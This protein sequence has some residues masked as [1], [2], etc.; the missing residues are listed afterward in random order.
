MEMVGSSN[1][2]YAGWMIG[3]WRVISNRNRRNDVINGRHA[4]VPGEIK[5]TTELTYSV[6]RPFFILTDFSQTVS[7]WPIIRAYANGNIVPINPYA[8]TTHFQTYA[9]DFDEIW[10]HVKSYRIYQTITAFNASADPV[11]G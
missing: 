9:T 5:A 10:F 6:L 2:R 11:S 7:F 4:D 1:Q 3:N 8:H